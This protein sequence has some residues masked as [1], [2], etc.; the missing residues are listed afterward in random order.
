M[1]K[2][3]LFFVGVCL[4]STALFSSCASFPQVEL[5]STKTV[6]STVKAAGADVYVHAS[7]LVLEDSLRKTET[8]LATER[9]KWFKT[10]KTSKEYLAG[11]TNYAGLVTEENNNK[12]AEL[13]KENE[14]LI[15]EAT[16]LVAEDR[17]L[18]KSAPKGKDGKAALVAI[19]ADLYVVESTTTDAKALV[20][21]GDLWGANGKLKVAA[22]KAAEIK[23]EL[24]SAIAK[25]SLR[26]KTRTVKRTK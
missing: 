18:L 3:K 21:T 4:A 22:Q 11:V 19:T 25:A 6:V 14:S 7:F 17:D 5:D 26:K 2:G 9:G 23:A 20:A 12:K 13:I 10:Y 16:T 15:V 8:V 1:R 24:S